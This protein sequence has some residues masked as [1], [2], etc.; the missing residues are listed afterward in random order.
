[1]DIGNVEQI[2]LNVRKVEC[3]TLHCIFPCD[4]IL[5]K[6]THKSS[7]L[8]YFITFMQD[9]HL[10]NELTQQFVVDRSCQLG[11]QFPHKRYIDLRQVACHQK[12]T[13]ADTEEGNDCTDHAALQDGS[14]SE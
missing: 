7:F 5:L 10:G 12:H 9:S 14:G 1:M 11:S 2:V 3:V 8:S 13:A 6:Q 4:T